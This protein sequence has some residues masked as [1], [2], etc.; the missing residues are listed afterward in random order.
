M[1]A[2]LLLVL[3]GAHVVQ[4]GETRSSLCKSSYGREHYAGLLALHNQIEST[5]LKVGQRIKLPT[6]EQLVRSEGLGEQAKSAW[7][8]IRTVSTRGPGP[9]G[10][11]LSDTHRRKSRTHSRRWCSSDV[12]RS[13]DGVPTRSSGR[14]QK[15][16]EGTL[17]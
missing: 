4:E 17:V 13:P 7:L 5:K 12:G 11:D 14:F 1:T 9:N 15:R 8:L 16:P 6:L 3:M 2:T 10:Y